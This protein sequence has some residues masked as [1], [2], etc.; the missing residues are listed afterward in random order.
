MSAADDGTIRLALARGDFSLQVDLALPA[1]GITAVFGP[2]GSGKT[3]LLRCVA[4]LE[5]GTD[6]L[7][8]I[9]G[10]VWQDDAQRI[11]VPT[12]RRPL[13]YVFQEAS[14]FD[15]L[16]VRGNLEYGLRRSGGA[17][18]AIAL[19][20]AIE[21][22]GIG[23]LLGRRPQ[24]LSGGERQRVA[25]ARALATQPRLLLL[26]EPLAALDLAR[27]RE[28]LPW[29]ERLRDELHIPMLYVTHSADE[30]ARLADALVVLDRGRVAASGP[31]AKVMAGIAGTLL[32]GDDAGALL[33]GT[34]GER[35]ARW[36]LARVDFDGG[37]LWLRDS[38]AE[39]GRRVRLRVLA[40]DV[41]IAT[42]EPRGTSIQNLLPVVVRAIAVDAHPSQALVQLACGN[43]ILLS[44]ITARAVDALGL[45][46]GTPVWAQVK[47]VAL[48]E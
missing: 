15:H 39:I 47:S 19:D 9:G 20:A 43:S 46:P 16:D 11:F 26:D 17:Q 22:L 29:L 18:Q 48:V 30:V 24:Q 45:Q 40:R 3:T 31:V 34:V 21:L 37:G 2:S 42:D 10:A 1:R 33:E 13:G 25:I 28:I 8:R 41:S 4:G 5:H 32:L 7:V 38:G 36:Q 14:L 27:R 12:W 35:D 6:A 44:R 23:A